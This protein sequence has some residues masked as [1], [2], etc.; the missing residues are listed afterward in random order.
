[1]YRVAIGQD[2]HRFT[3]PEECKRLILGGIY[4]DNCPGLKG[5]S[6][7]DVV[8]HALTN[9]VSGISCINILGERADK[10]CLEQG[11]TDSSVY[12]KEALKTLE[13]SEIVHVSI[14]I[15]ALKPK[16]S[17]Y[18]K[19]MRENIAH[20]LCIDSKSVGI[21]A[22][23]GEGLTEFGKGNGIFCTA[24]ITVRKTQGDGSSV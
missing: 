5:N 23:T 18:I 13:N 7:A 2:S 4:I 19:P 10:L 9:A 24:I 1:M 11:I 17:P 15:E 16:L 20:L 14:S 8:L 3:E 12:L 22:T 21:T 6:D